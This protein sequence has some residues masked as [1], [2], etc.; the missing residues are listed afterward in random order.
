[1][2]PGFA[3]VAALRTAEALRRHLEACGAALPFD[4]T[5]APTGT[6]PL[7]RPLER[8]GLRPG[9]RFCILPMEGWDGT[10]EGAPSELTRRRW[11][12]FGESGA[13]LIWGGEAAAVRPDG[14]GNPAQLVIGDATWGKIARLREELVAAHR[15]SCGTDEGLVVGLQLTHSGRYAR[16][17]AWERA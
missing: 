12:H 3:R 2:D 10:P 15:A 16:P 7:A 14:R 5:L 8:D 9:N 4:G 6:S 13:K 11:V 1:M 17:N